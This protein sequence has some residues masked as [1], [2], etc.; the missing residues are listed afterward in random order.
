MNTTE[1]PLCLSSG[2]RARDSHTWAKNFSPKPSCHSLSG[3]AKKSPRRTAPALLTRMSSRPHFCVTACA[4]SVAAPSCQQ[5]GDE[6][7]RVA[8]RL[9]DL[10]RDL[11]ERRLGRAR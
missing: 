4:S 8:A 1:P 6:H 3:V 9:A 10:G 2:H 7:V 11:V 5:I